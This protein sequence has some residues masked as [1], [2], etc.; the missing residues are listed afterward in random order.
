MDINYTIIRSKRRT[1]SIN[2]DL[3][4]NILVKAP[5]KISKDY[6]NNFINLKSKW[7]NKKI[8]QQKEKNI[9]KKEIEN[10]FMFLGKIYDVNLDDNNGIKITDDKIYLPKTN[11]KNL[12]LKYLNEN[13]L[14]YCKL[15][16]NLI[17]GIT[18]INFNSLKISNSKMYW[19]IC[20]SKKEIKIN[21][22][23]IMLPE[24]IIKYILI[25]ELCHNIYLNHS[26]DFWKLVEKYLPDYKKLRK[27]LKGYSYLFQLYR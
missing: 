27:N 8:K 11:E 5:L 12:I 7:I 9:I 15:S 10:R 3:E 17:C 20:N 4:G 26:A 22:R 23:I 19:G 6:I 18:K 13:S 21:C 1:M 2:I 14:N 25:H 24:D 16:F